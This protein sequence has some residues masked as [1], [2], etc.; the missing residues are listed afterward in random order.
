MNE[1]RTDKPRDEPISEDVSSGQLLIPVKECRR[2]LGGIGNTKFYEE[3]A[4]GRLKLIKMGRRS[5][6]T[7]AE[8]KRYVVALQE[9]AATGSDTDV[10]ETPD[11]EA[12]A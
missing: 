2:Q 12:A 9:N 1:T 3:V 10:A 5:F 4:A 8:L 6:A 11:A 7:P